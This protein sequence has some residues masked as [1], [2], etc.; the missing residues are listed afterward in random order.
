[1]GKACWLLAFLLLFLYSSGQKT[2]VVHVAC[3]N[4]ENPVCIDEGK[5]ALSWQLTASPA[6]V[7]TRPGLLREA[8]Y[9]NI[10]QSAYR[11]I[12]ADDSVMLQRDS[13]NAWDS[14]KV[15]SDQSI[16]VRYAGRK[17]EAAKQYWWKVMVWDKHG[18]PSAWSKCA[19]WRMGL[20]DAA[21]WHGAKWIGYDSLP[22]SLRTVPAVAG[23]WMPRWQGVHDVLPLLRKPFVVHKAVRSAMAYV[24]GLGQFCLRLN[25]QKCGDHFLDP[26]WTKYDKHAL[27]VAFDV[28]GELHQGANVL[29]VML[30]NGFY[31][32][33]GD[34]YRKLSG[35]YGYP[36]M[37]C[38]LLICYQDGS[39]E[40]IVSDTS[41]K[42]T[43]GPVTFS[44]IYG[45]EDYDARL[46]QEGW[47]RPA[48]DDKTWND[49]VL[50][51]GPLKLDAQMAEPLKVFEHFAPIKVT[52]PKG[53]F[54]LYD[55]GQ[56]ASG[57]PY[58]EVSGKRG[59]VIKLTPAEL[60][61]DDGLAM[62]KWIGEPVSFSYT[63]KG[64][65]KEVWQPEFM[66]YGFRYIQVEGGVPDGKPNPGQLP[67]IVGVQ[68]LHTRN[69]AARIGSFFCSNELFNKTF[70][71]ID[72]AIQSNTAS[73]FTDC[74]HREKLGWLE[75]AHLVGA[76]IRYN[77]DISNL[78][79]KVVRDMIQS[80][81][82]DGL[83][84]DI[85][86]EYTQFE[87]GF[88]DS[89]E[90]GSSGII[91]PWYAYQWYGDRSILE[92]SYSMMT[93]YAGYLEGKSK[94]HIL[95]FGLGDWYDIG[96]KPP[97]ES[98][99]T[100]SGITSTAIYYYDLTIL[101]RVAALLGRDF[102][103]ARY[104]SLAA[105]VR[106]A[107]NR[108]FFHSDTKQYGTGSQTANAM[109]VYMGLVDSTDKAAVVENIVQDIRSRHNS[110]TAGD[111]GYRYLLRVLDD[112]GRSDVIYDMNS[113]FDRPGYGYQ[114][115]HGATALT[116]S[117]QAYRDVSNNHFMLGHL[118]E[119][120]YSGLAGIRPAAGTIAFREI[121]IRPDPVGDVTSASA[122]VESPYGLISSRW[123][124]G[125]QMFHLIVRIPPNARGRIFLPAGPSS[126]VSESGHALGKDKDIMYYG[127]ED[128]RAVYG[129]GSGEYDF[130]VRY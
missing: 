63:L 123:S 103:A 127:F 83:I 121:D 104:A 11:V 128:G 10:G 43:G 33:P 77:Y 73:I 17:L 126:V 87:Y 22:D 99:L 71:L 84:P 24:C 114:L 52:E 66:Y 3:E 106:D 28:T 14:R 129:V 12:V 107:F 100:P 29:G 15:M 78:L 62:Q 61:G 91:L 13:G 97:G 36:K 60:T 119:W 26:G 37:I 72:W 59:S 23:E 74:P 64:T 81:N 125:K 18:K 111:I 41:W 44:S 20:L 65:G 88:R 86:P 19:S 110:L 56:N 124:R 53:G 67:V 46:E 98:Q 30:G 42:T 5:P 38:R 6:N 101:S 70:N 112:A 34:R 4:K 117:W 40:D 82:A 109:A 21:D 79:Q 90:W 116:E 113:G 118:M 49:A 55:L 45:G 32:I 51:E 95:Y 108:T 39:V 122:S 94:D 8:A 68:G 130:L 2:A 85:A 54:W 31:F 93:R 89:P 47:D 92:E 120:F 105:Q 9:R 80:Q 102:D 27:Y 1:M 58:L 57:I 50:V 75:E 115:A 48:F 76:S 25:G 35:A 7:H 96:P 69:A 16:Q